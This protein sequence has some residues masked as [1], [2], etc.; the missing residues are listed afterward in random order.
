MGRSE[1]CKIMIISLTGFMGCGKS[2]VGKK[3]SELLCCRFM[4]LDDEIVAREGRSIA[5]IFEKDGESE[6]RRIEK[7]VLS[8]SLGR[9]DSDANPETTSKANTDLILALGGGAVMTEGSEEMVHERTLCI[10]LKASVETLIEHLTGETDGRPMLSQ[11]KG[12][13]SAVSNCSQSVMS[14]EVETSSL[15][16]RILTLM[17]KRAATY[18]RTAHIIIETDGKSVEEIAVEIAA[19]AGTFA[20]NAS[21]RDTF[22]YS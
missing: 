4:D 10:Y 22:Q 15:R 14:S 21:L 16:K 6:F 3:L 12:A 7:E 18:E 5:E 19:K 17:S 9:K 11:S 13:Q 1:I 20:T 8:N 2:S